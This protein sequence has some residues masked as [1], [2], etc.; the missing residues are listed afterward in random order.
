VKVIARE[1]FGQDN[2]PY[3]DA[4]RHPF[5]R[6]LAAHGESDISSLL[7]HPFIV[8][9]RDM[10][11]T[12]YHW[13]LLYEY[14]SGGQMLDYIISHGRLKEKRARKFACQLGSALAYCHKQNIV[15]R[16]IKIENILISKNDDIKLVDF[17]CSSLFTQDEYFPEHCRSGA[18][19]FAAPE[20]ISGTPYIGPEVDIWSFG[21]VLYTLVCGKMPFNRQ[22]MELEYPA[23]LTT[24]LFI[25]CPLWYRDHL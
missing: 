22:P 18:L 7:S 17:C 16:N 12:D 1:S 11:K 15:H 21:I 9:M 6:D 8:N 24:G 23:W 10:T 5:C 3:D 19:Y 25:S 14:V 2:W 20:L 13:Y 4:Q